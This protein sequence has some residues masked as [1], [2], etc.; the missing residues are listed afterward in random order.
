MLGGESLSLQ[1]DSCLRAVSRPPLQPIPFVICSTD[2]KMGLLTLKS[3]AR[4]SDFPHLN[5]SQI[6]LVELLLVTLSLLLLLYALTTHAHSHESTTGAG[7]LESGKWGAHLSSGH[8][9]WP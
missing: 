6:R 5:W 3:R 2:Q 7:S 4:G 8:H 1:T 9:P